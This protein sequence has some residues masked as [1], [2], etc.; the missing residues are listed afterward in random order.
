M[1][2]RSPPC[3][4]RVFVRTCHV[5]CLFSVVVCCLCHVCSQHIGIAG[6]RGTTIFIAHCQRNAYCKLI[7]LTAHCIDR[8]EGAARPQCSCVYKAASEGGAGTAVGAVL[9]TASKKKAGRLDA[10][11]RAVF[12]AVASSAQ[13]AVCPWFPLRRLQGFLRHLVLHIVDQMLCA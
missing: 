1:T 6:S 11:S 5:W 7:S 12:V 8:V 13:D 3:G 4:R 9:K 2:P 10:L